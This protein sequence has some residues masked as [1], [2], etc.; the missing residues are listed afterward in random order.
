MFVVAMPPAIKV[1][2]IGIAVHVPP[3]PASGDMHLAMLVI[4]IPA[5]IQV[6][7]VRIAMHVA[8]VMAMPVVSV[9]VD[10]LRSMHDRIGDRRNAQRARGQALCCCECQ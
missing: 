9:D 3:V 2:P 8:V 5:A 6:P 10:V 7:A 1:R 4:P